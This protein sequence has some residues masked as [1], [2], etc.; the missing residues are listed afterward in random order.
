MLFNSS[1]IRAGSGEYLLMDRAEQ[2]YN[3]RLPIF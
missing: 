1:A 2:I 3:S